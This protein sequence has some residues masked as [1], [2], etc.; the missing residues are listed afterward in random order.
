[1]CDYTIVDTDPVCK[2][3]SQRFTCNE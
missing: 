2:R 1:M 3:T